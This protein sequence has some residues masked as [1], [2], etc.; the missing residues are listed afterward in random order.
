MYM[1][2]PTQQNFMVEDETEL[3]N[4]PYMG[5]EVLDGSFIEE[6]IK[7]YDGKWH[8]DKEGDFMDDVIFVDLVQALIPFQ[9]ITEMDTSSPIKR[10]ASMDASSPVKRTSSMD[11]E[12]PVKRT[13]SM[14]KDH[15]VKRT[16]S[17]DKEHPIRRTTSMDKE[18]SI[19]S[20]E[21]DRKPRTS[22][23]GMCTSSVYTHFHMAYDTYVTLSSFLISRISFTRDGHLISP[24][25]R[26]ASVCLDVAKMF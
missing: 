9:N 25:Y 7:N 16:V 13:C 24:V 20:R 2:A 22:R 19:E 8:G 11:K 5:D 10:T 1:W 12:L 15:P 6:L 3:H 23:E 21:N 4:I 18:E 26:F 17:V 14:D